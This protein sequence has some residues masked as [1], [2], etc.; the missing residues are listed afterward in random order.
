MCGYVYC[1][2]DHGA[3]GVK[4]NRGL[5]GQIG[6]PGQKVQIEVA[7][8]SECHVT[9][10]YSHCYPKGQPGKPGIDAIPG[11]KGRRGPPGEQVC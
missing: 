4:G 3:K 2:Q 7:L 10:L 8:S 1:V 9:I 11:V 6:V 5:P